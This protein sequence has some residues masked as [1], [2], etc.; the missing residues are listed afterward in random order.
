MRQVEY[1]APT[2]RRSMS[3]QRRVKIYLSRNG[4]CWNCRQQIRTGEKWFI[5]HPDAV[6]LGGSDKDEDLWP[7]HVKKCKREKDAADAKLIAKRNAII[8]KDCVDRPKRPFP[9][10]V[11][12]WGKHR[13]KSFKD[14][15]ED[16]S[17]DG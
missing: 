17:H 11:D 16:N 14:I 13:T 3:K 1:I 2:K 4:I 6:N 5:E 9:K 10:R 12:P 15:H 7:A 8:D